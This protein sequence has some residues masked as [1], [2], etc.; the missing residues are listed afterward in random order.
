MKDN[1]S[2]IKKVEN[3]IQIV[4]NEFKSNATQYFTENDIV[5]YFYS[6]LQREL[7]ND[8]YLDKDGKRHF[9]VH[10]EY[11]TP[12]KLDMRG[13]SCE[14]MS[15][16][17]KHK[18]GH[19]DIV[20]LNPE[21]I[22]SHTYEEIKAQSFRDFMNTFKSNVNKPIVL[23]GIEFMLSRDEF[24]SIDDEKRF[25]DKTKQDARKLALTDKGF[26]G[27]KR[28]LAFIKGTPRNKYGHILSKASESNKTIQIIWEDNQ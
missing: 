20:I 24:K 1:E 28:M 2:I 6:K 18:R 26:M 15:E 13:S 16:K 8:E 14:I 21:F 27:N 19:Y 10:G 9:L 3:T 12:T 23:Y 22:G 17:S 11:P 4:I 25:W 5:M 7:G